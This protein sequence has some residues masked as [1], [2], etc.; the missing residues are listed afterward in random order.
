[1]WKL[2][3]RFRPWRWN[4]SNVSPLCTKWTKC[5][6]SCIKCRVSYS[7]SQCPERAAVLVW[8]PT[9]FGIWS[10]SFCHR[11]NLT[12]H[13]ILGEFLVRKEV[14]FILGNHRSWISHILYINNHLWCCM[15]WI[16]WIFS[17]S[18]DILTCD[19]I[20]CIHCDDLSNWISVNSFNYA[21]D[22]V[23][24]ER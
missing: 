21:K 22:F 11:S 5:N 6:L 17:A 2:Q 4:F 7:S 15:D 9:D 13:N 18:A 20:H 23:R 19:R 1:M 14:D 8:A 16:S 24:F 12:I 10:H 3:F